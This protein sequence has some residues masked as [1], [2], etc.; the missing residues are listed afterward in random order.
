MVT[1][2]PAVQV[3]A[4]CD[5]ASTIPAAVALLMDSNAVRNLCVSRPRQRQ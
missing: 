2:S 5:T 1:L 4:I 3:S